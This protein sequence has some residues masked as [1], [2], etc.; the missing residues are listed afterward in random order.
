MRSG[1]VRKA[2]IALAFGVCAVTMLPAQQG[3]GAGGAG[4]RRLPRSRT[5]AVHLHIMRRNL[6]ICQ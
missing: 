6:H 5:F 4:T 2:S 3:G 1:W